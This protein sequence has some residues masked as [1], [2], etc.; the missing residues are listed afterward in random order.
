M[1]A[2]TTAPCSGGS[3]P[4]STIGSMSVS[5]RSSLASS[6]S[7]TCGH[8]APYITTAYL[9]YDCKAAK[10]T[11]STGIRFAQYERKRHVP[12]RCHC[13]SHH[14]SECAGC[15]G[16]GRARGFRGHHPRP[17]AQE[18]PSEG[19][20]DTRGG[21]MRALQ[22]SVLQGAMMLMQAAE[23]A[24]PAGRAAKPTSHNHQKKFSSASAWCAHAMPTWNDHARTCVNA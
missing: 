17:P 12:C 9:Q 5:T 23:P 10:A 22:L 7:F 21:V 15:F 24:S 20:M 1:L 4:S 14:P 11:R 13:Q 16:A 18:T 3:E 19:R 6:V 2:M 8:H